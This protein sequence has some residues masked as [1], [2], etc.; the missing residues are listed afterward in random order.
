MKERGSG[1]VRC[2]DV[3]NHQHNNQF[4]EVHNATLTILV[5]REEGGR[6]P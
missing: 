1:S 4:M 3:S 5:T 2:R 6:L